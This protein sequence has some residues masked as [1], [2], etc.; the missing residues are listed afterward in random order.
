MYTMNDMVGNNRLIITEYS[1]LVKYMQAES[2]L[3]KAGIEIDGVDKN[4]HGFR[5]AANKKVLGIIKKLDF[6]INSSK[7]VE[8]IAGIST[9]SYRR[10]DDIIKN[11]RLSELDNT[12]T[13]DMKDKIKGIQDLFDVHGLGPAAV[14]KMVTKDGIHN[15]EQL[16]RAVE[17]GSITLNRKAMLGLKYFDVQKKKIPRQ[18]TTNIMKFLKKNLGKIDKK[19]VLEICGS[20]RR[21]KKFS[22][23]IDVL[24]YHPDVKTLRKFSADHNGYLKKFVKL[25]RNANYI[26]DDITDG[27]ISKKYMGYAKYKAY[28][29]RRIDIQFVPYESRFSA[30]LYFTGPH[31]LNDYM[32]LQAKKRDMR[33]NEYG[34]YKGRDV[35]IEKARPMKAT[36]EK[37]F[38]D[39]LGMKYLEPKEREIYNN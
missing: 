13:R 25:L 10:I 2:L 34:I 7:D 22:G 12:Y 28:D 36:S 5:L 3:L 18:E 24:I 21:G 11:G 17:N 29:T 4:T 8:N 27:N 33:L 20:Y 16:C 23:D 30:L 39:I 14:K 31:Q 32:R 37:T 6:K 9:H 35:D 1:R 26:V 38:F 19:F 15:L